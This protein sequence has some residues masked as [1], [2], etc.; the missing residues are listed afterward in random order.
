MP[1]VWP[2]F[3]D[4][5]APINTNAGVSRQKLARARA[6]VPSIVVELITGGMVESYR[7]EAAL[8]GKEGAVHH[9]RTRR[10]SRLGVK[11]DRGEPTA[12]MA[13]S[14]MP[15]KQKIS[16]ASGCVPS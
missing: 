7:R 15:P 4:E 5:L 8:D 13:T 2:S 11:R 9:R 3:I 10:R 1:S 12:S 14:A 6:I 16:T